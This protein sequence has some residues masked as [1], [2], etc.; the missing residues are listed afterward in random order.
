LEKRRTMLRPYNGKETLPEKEN[1]I[2][3]KLKFLQKPT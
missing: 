1:V 2:K 3:G